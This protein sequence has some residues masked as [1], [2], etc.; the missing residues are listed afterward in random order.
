MTLE[1][2]GRTSSDYLNQLIREDNREAGHSY[3]YNYDDAGNRTSKKVYAF[4]LGNL[5]SV[6]ADYSYTYSSSGWGDRLVYDE[7][8]YSNI[9]YDAIGNPIYIED[10]DDPDCY[11][12]LTW[13]GRQLASITSYT[14][15]AGSSVRF[16]YNAGSI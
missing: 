14:T 5:G 15:D 10:S 9:T 3:T 16:T 12:E 4:T 8:T 1:E 11:K 6:L 13:N 2:H 7:G